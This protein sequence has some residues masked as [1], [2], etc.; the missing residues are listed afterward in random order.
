[1]KLQKSYAMT[2][3]MLHYEEVRKFHIPVREDKINEVWYYGL[4]EISELIRRLKIPCA[5]Y[6]EGDQS[7]KIG[8]GNSKKGHTVQIYRKNKSTAKVST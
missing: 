6:R 5:R 8:T 1:M 4:S 2:E 3:H 7:Q